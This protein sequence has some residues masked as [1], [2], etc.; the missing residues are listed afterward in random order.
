[1]QI[2][3]GVTA[4]AQKVV[5][6]GTEGIGKT[7]ISAQFPNPLFI[8]TEGSTSNMDVARMDR[9]SSWQFLLQQIDFVKQN[10]PCK[11]LVID[12]IDWAERFAI[13]HV[14]SSAGKTSIT[15]FGY[16]EGF[17]QLEE[18]F[19]RFLNRLS[20]L[21][22][23]GINVVLT[24]HAKITKFEQ[25]DEMGAYDRWELKLGNKTTAKTAA[26][27]K[28]W[29]DMVLFANY[30]TFSVAVDDKGKKHKGQG[31]VRT[32]YANHHPAWDAK[33]RHGLPDEFPMEYAQ[34]AHIFNGQ[35]L[36]QV[37]ETWTSQPAPQQPVA[38]P[39]QPAPQQQMASGPE[40]APA[41][42]AQT[43]TATPE[44]P[45]Q[46]PTTAP[47]P[48]QPTPAAEPAPYDPPA[49]IS[50]AIPKALQDLMLK[51]GVTEN[52]IQIVVSQKGYYPIDTPIVNYDSSFIDGVLVGAWPQVLEMIKQAGLDLPF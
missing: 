46:Q 16:G 43:P 35:A 34:I 25:P 20:D 7:S 44:P 1:M 37:Q 15:G 51:D 17:I 26:L 38:P 48:P 9:P 6:Y 45:V 42:V 18:E 30:K 41:Q 47:A 36:E 22:E 11:T 14:V 50:S 40:V 52:A 32:F 2:T 29:A 39:V 24:A 28:E 31:G 3:R 4:K 5:I 33:N 21:V 12:T 23:L 10:Q 13:E 19:G 49:P 8:D 27:V